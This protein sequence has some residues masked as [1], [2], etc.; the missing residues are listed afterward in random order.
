MKAV[1]LVGGK[2]TRLQPLTANLP[3][4][5]VPV[6]NRP[7][8][9][10]LFRHLSRFEISEIIL[11]LGHLA[12][13][14]EECFGNG[15]RLGLK[16]R[17]VV[18]D[19]PR[20][21]AGGI[22]NVEKFLDG[23]FIALN[24]DVFTDLDISAM[25]DFH[26]QKKA[27]VTVALGQADDPTQYGVIET[28]PENRILSFREKPAAGELTG[29]MVN[30]G[31]YVL[32]PEV[33]AQIPPRIEV[34]IE[35]GT[36][37][38]LLA[39]GK[40]LFAYGSPA[41]WLDIGTPER[42]LQLQGDLMS[43]RCQQDIFDPVQGVKAGENSNVS[44]SAQITG[45]VIIGSNCFIGNRVRLV[46]PVTIGDGCNISAETVIENS[47]IWANAWTGPRVTIR[48]SIIADHC[49][50]QANSVI[51]GAVLGDHVTVTEGSRI[52]PGSRIES[53]TVVE[54]TA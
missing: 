31:T 3:K 40:P 41:Y 46:G 21:S 32:E 19:S 45:P 7:F 10:H 11:A 1:I 16:L 50:F 30:I 29:N 6:L 22:K 36:F 17:Y 14:I 13:P 53:G 35:R 51:E 12:A 8:L 44:P 5:M 23:T 33:L 48:N 52:N 43:G 34:S 27:M 47:V 4:A 18:E 54:R 9:E 37:P 20:G 15:S 28:D 2:A 49:Y 24:G 38:Q 25:V 42:Y 26:R 39:Q